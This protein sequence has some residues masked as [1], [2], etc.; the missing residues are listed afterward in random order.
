MWLSKMLSKGSHHQQAERGAVTVSDA[1]AP[2][3]SASLGA[4]S[5]VSCMPYGY[6]SRAPVGEEVLVLP[7][8][9]GNAVLGTA[10]KSTALA[11]G[12]VQITS[13]GGACILLKND[14]SVVIN[15]L[16]IDKEGRIIS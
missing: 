2:E 13:K 8:A 1:A 16:T 9:D 6:C 3:A 11:S 14:G 7:C 5:A 12:E 15:S 4:R 10:A